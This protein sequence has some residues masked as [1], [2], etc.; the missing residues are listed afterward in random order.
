MTGDAQMISEYVVT[1]DAANKI[2]GL[3]ITFFMLLIAIHSGAEVAR[4]KKLR[5]R[6]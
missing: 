1:A 5:R 6:K 4:L 3:L 2:L